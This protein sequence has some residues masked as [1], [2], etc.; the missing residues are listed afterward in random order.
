MA[1]PIPQVDELAIQAIKYLKPSNG[2]CKHVR[3]G[4]VE[5]STSCDAARTK[6]QKCPCP[7][8]PSDIESGGVSCGAAMRMYRT[9][10]Y[11]KS[12]DPES[13]QDYFTHR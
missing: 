4:A 2:V 13:V 9:R 5:F 12:L 1:N 6:A 7:R 3:N 11:W 10:T 8:Q